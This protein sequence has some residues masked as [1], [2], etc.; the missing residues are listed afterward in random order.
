MNKQWVKF[1]KSIKYIIGQTLE[2]I[3]KMEMN[4][5]IESSL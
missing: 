2:K 3:D 1:E 4:T 5:K